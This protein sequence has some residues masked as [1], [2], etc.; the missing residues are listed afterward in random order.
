MSLAP[1]LYDYDFENDPIATL[2]RLRAEDP[3]HWSRHG[4][5]YLTRYD[6]CAMVLKDPARFSSMR[7]RLGRRQSAGH[8]QG[9]GRRQSEDRAG[10]QPHPRPI[11]QPDGRAG[12][13]PHSRPGGLGLLEAQHRGAPGRASRR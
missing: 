13:H 8:G 7:G 4:F 2:N 11:V 3:V 1:D 9:S 5:W 12:P 6:D 10:P